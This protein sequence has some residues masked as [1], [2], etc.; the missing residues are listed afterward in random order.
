[1]GPTSTEPFSANCITPTPSFRKG[2]ISEELNNLPI[3]PHGNGCLS[4]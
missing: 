3:V 4:D 2:V 1:M